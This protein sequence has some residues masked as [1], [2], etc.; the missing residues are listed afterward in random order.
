M[1]IELLE[2]TGK[3]LAFHLPH[4]SERE[5]SLG[6]E[7]LGGQSKLSRALEMIVSHPFP[8][9]LPTLMRQNCLKLAVVRMKRNGLGPRLPIGWVVEVM[10]AA[11]PRAEWKHQN[12][13]V[14]GLF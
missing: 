1:T 11:Q 10:L 7:E 4:E 14:L 5:L 9:V 2:T 13:K 8:T 12:P 3:T 6:G